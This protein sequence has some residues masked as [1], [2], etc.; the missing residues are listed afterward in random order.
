M[1][2]SFVTRYAM[3]RGS[4]VDNY[5]VPLAGASGDLK[6]DIKLN[7]S[8]TYLV[9]EH[10]LL[11]YLFSL[12]ADFVVELK[13]NERRTGEEVRQQSQ[14]RPEHWRMDPFKE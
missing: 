2:H 7:Q 11:C 8:F 13:K 10:H 9:V 14:Q 5:M 12:R 1:L 6:N 3:Y 4:Q